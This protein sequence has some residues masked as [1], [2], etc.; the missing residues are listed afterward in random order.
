MERF[1]NKTFLI[2]W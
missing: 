1:Y 2:R